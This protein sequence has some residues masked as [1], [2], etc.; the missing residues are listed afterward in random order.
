MRAT[1]KRGLALLG[2]ARPASGATILIY[3]R[4]GG[5]TPDERDVS[6]E[7]FRHQLDV[8]AGHQVVTL[9]EALDGLE[10]RD[11]S[12]RVVLTFDDGFADVHDAVLPL[13][14][15]RRLPF[16]LYL[17]TAYLGGLMHWDGSTAKAAGPALRWTQAAELVSSGLCTLGNHT[18]SHA[19][20]EALTEAELDRCTAEIEDRLGVTPRHFAYPWGVAVPA[21]ES[22]LRARFRSSVTGELGRN[23]PG[24]DPMRLQRV[25]VRRTDPPAFFEA[26]L[27]GGLGAE[28][29]YARMVSAAKAVGISA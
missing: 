11:R 10:A 6:A 5:G 17:A 21:M 26:K 18:H 24:V 15:E 13:L 4:V 14:V 9:D 22:A 7:G 3:H 29:A 28:R 19:R 25:P 12:P 8:L 20:P 2:G 16:T 23:L 1:V 27:R